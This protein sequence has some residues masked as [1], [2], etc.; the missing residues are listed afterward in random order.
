MSSSKEDD[1]YE[2]LAGGAL[3]ERAAGLKPGTSLGRLKTG[4]MGAGA[5]SGGNDGAAGPRPMTSVKG[6][7]FQSRQLAT[8]MTGAGGK[9]VSALDAV[10]ARTGGPAPPLAD[11]TENSPEEAAKEMERKV[12]ALIEAAAKAAAAGDAV[13]ALE[14]AKEA[15]RKERQL[16]KFKDSNGLSDSISLDLTYCC[17]FNLAHAVSE[18]LLVEGASVA[19]RR[20]PASLLIIFDSPCVCCSTI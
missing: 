6:A 3:E 11:K 18:G 7:G 16:V 19:F 20:T 17:A 9:A 13:M 15:G 14:R 1:L 2:G 10:A 5:N 8:A 12:H 4:M